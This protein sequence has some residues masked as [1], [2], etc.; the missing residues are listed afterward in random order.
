MS[1][2]RRCSECD[3]WTNGTKRSANRGLADHQRST[4]HMGQG[5]S[6]GDVAPG[7][8]GPTP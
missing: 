3:Y 8:K 6:L 4:G 2:Y 7:S 5:R 1:V